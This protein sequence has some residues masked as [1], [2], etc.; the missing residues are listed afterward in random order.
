MALESAA[1]Q[2]GTSAVVQS[3]GKAR[4]FR[5][6]YQ[7]P[8]LP[9]TAPPC[10][11]LAQDPRYLLPPDVTH[12]AGEKPERGRCAKKPYGG[13]MSVIFCCRKTVVEERSG[14]WSGKRVRS[15]SS[16]PNGKR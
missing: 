14:R 15:R 12:I 6:E 11:R 10:A 5:Q 9:I 2:Y 8:A 7:P 3:V 1:A 16:R 4:A 13:D